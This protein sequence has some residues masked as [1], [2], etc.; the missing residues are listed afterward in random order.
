MLVRHVAEPA[1]FQGDLGVGAW[2]S[3]GISRNVS[4]PDSA[5]LRKARV[6]NLP[7]VVKPVIVREATSNRSGTNSPGWLGTADADRSNRNLRDPRERPA[8]RAR[9]AANVWRECITAVRLV[10]ESEGFIVALTPLTTAERRDPAEIMQLSNARRPAWT[11]VPLRKSRP[12]APPHR[13][14]RR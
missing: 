4:E 14:N 7:K 8:S 12:L 10:W 2:G 13:R 11:S 3:E 6:A 9:R 1:A 5:S